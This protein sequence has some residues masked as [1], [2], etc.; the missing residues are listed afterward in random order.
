MVMAP[1][2]ANLLELR[3]GGVRSLPLPRC[4]N[5][6]HHLPIPLFPLCRQYANTTR[7]DRRGLFDAL[8]LLTALFTL[9]A[10]YPQFKDCGL[11]G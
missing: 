5:P 1:D 4:E 7:G 8:I 10:Q 3:Q 9:F 6:E 2:V 11:V